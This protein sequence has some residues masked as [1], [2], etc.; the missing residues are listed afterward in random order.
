MNPVFTSADLQDITPGGELV[1][2]PGTL[3]TAAARDEA[4]RRGISLRVSAAANRTNDGVGA[5]ASATPL[6]VA[7]PSAPIA[8][9]TTTDA[10]IRAVT[11]EVIAYLSWSPRPQLGGGRGALE[12]VDCH[13]R[14]GERHAPSERLAVD[15]V[16]ALID[17]TLLKP[18]ATHSEIDRLCHEAVEFG[19]AT[20][21]VNPWYV[22]LAARLLHGTAVKVCTVVGFPLGAT[23]PKIKA[24]EAEEAIKLGAQEIDVVQN[25][26]AL[27]SGQNERVEVDLRG[28][29]EISHQAG[30]I[31]KVILETV[32]L[33]REQKVRGALLV[34]RAGADFV[35]TSTGFASG[36][37]TVEDV[38]LLRETVGCEMG[39]KAS[40]GIRNL[41]DLR[42]LASAG[43]TRIG[44]SS[45][46]KILQQLRGIAG[47][48]APSRSS[49]GDPP[50]G[51]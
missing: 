31:C 24:H 22:P 39:V 1:L 33:N 47:V 25:V 21:C 9:P 41:D 34:K 5:V 38:A 10:Y 43:A 2:A 20:V 15:T 26:G 13:G 40:G 32:L 19:F 7:A 46:V 6:I 36:G 11:E 3:V 35:K 16:A 45:G 18:D 12:P 30:A 37:A 51:E 42:A 28:V 23:L 44:T 48:A 4:A 29:V 8:V 27:K 17:H 49:G 50:A 14:T